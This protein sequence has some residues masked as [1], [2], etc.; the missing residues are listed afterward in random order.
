MG[1]IIAFFDSVGLGVYAVVG[2]QKSLDASL[3]MP[4]SIMVGMIN[5]AGAVCYAISW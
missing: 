3:S 4:A 2:L 1:K 5:A